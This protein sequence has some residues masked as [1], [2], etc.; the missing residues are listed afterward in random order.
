[1]G[2]EGFA[3]EYQEPLMLENGQADDTPTA[4]ETEQPPQ[5]QQQHEQQQSGGIFSSSTLAALNKAKV[6]V[7]AKPQAAAG[8]LVAYDSDSD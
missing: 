8:P 6:A 3:M 2:R 7:A 5:E 4:Q 1:M